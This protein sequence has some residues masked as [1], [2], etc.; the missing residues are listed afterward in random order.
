MQGTVEEF[1]VAS[2][3]ANVAERLSVADSAVLVTVRPGSVEVETQVTSSQEDKADEINSTFTQ[4]A[5]DL[6]LAS[7]FFG[8]TIEELSPPRLTV[9]LAASPAPP[10]PLDDAVDDDLSGQ[11]TGGT[12]GMPTSTLIYIVVPAAIVFLGLACALAYAVSL[13]RKKSRHVI[14]IEDSRRKD[15]ARVHD[16]QEQRTQKLMRSL[17]EIKRNNSLTRKGRKPPSYR[18]STGDVTAA[19]CA[20]DS[21]RDSP[22][23][24]VSQYGSQPVWLSNMESAIA[25]QERREDDNEL[26]IDQIEAEILAAP[27]VAAREA[28][29]IIGSAS[30]LHTPSPAS[31]PGKL[32]TSRLTPSLSSPRLPTPRPS[33]LRP[34]SGT[35]FPSPPVGA[36]RSPR[37]NST[38][39]M[40]SRNDLM[41]SI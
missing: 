30:G 25:A 40:A 15:L 19:A 31:T 2:Y 21:P 26:T 41:A 27:E 39:L 32:R 9:Q 23:S 10:R 38:D 16:L 5:A 18:M 33:S 6:D 34:S 17:L 35:R 14:E 24:F 28:S 3:T 13:L 12:S 1:D 37:S 8:V 22:R 36:A 7:D 29:A 4:L 11:K 20:C